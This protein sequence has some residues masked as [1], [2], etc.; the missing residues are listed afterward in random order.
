M[1]KLLTLEI[2]LSLIDA[3]FNNLFTRGHD[4]CKNIFK[5]ANV[6]DLWLKQIYYQI[7]PQNTSQNFKNL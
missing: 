1:Q 7:F 2:D 5:L 4:A 6:D 3:I